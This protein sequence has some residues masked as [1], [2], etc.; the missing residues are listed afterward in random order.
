MPMTTVI[1]TDKGKLKFIT[2]QY[3]TGLY[4]ALYKEGC[5]MPDQLSSHLTEE[6]FHKKMREQIG[7]KNNHTFVE[8]ES[9]TIGKKNNH[10]FVEEES[11]TL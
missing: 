9:T 8:E 3:V 1:K 4:V 6:D 5:S 10:T 7:K 11:T 2:Q